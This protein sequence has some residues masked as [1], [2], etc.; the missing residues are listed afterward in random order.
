MNQASTSPKS[1]A[2]IT[3]N[4]TGYATRLLV[5]TYYVDKTFIP[6]RLMRQVSGHTPMPIVE[7]VAYF[8]LSYDLYNDTAGTQAVNQCN[9]GASVACNPSPGSVGLLPN[10]ITKIN[11]LHMAL[12]SSLKGAQGGF[13]GLDL[14]TSVS[15]RDLTYN[16]NYP[17]GP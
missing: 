9:P 3:T 17:I 14:Q 2:S 10:Q 11:I 15:A 12:T 5:I 13:Q 8:K 1:L 7:N 4:T 16:N 6:Y